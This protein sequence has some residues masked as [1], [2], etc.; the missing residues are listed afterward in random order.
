M[1][2]TSGKTMHLGM[3]DRGF[4]VVTQ[5]RNLLPF[6]EP[7][8]LLLLSQ[9]FTTGPCP[10]PDE[11]TLQRHTLSLSAIILSSH[12]YLALKFSKQNCL[13]FFDVILITC[14]VSVMEH[15][16]VMSEIV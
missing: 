4:T 6:M 5:S 8:D 13:C 7:E 15:N 11:F 2:D 1:N 9:K 12:L 16:N 10:G 3:M 14:I